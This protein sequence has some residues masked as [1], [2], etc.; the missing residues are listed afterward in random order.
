[1]HMSSHWHY[2]INNACMQAK[3]YMPVAAQIYNLYNYSQLE[4]SIMCASAHAHACGSE[5]WTTSYAYT[6][7]HMLI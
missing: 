1:M 3:T 7:L 6:Q 2:Y 5:F 4:C